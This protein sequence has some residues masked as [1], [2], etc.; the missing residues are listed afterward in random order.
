MHSAFFTNAHGVSSMRELVILAKQGGNYLLMDTA[1]QNGMNTM[2]LF[3]VEPVSNEWCL[4]SWTELNT[5][6]EG[7]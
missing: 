7:R 4:I 1:S 6:V 2:Y 5:F 3:Y